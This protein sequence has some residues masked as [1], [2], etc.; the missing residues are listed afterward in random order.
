MFLPFYLLA[1]V[2]TLHVAAP[3]YITSTFL[4]GKIGEGMVG[5]IYAGASIITLACFFF[6]GSLLKKRGDY[7]LT[8]TLMALDFVATVGLAALK[9]PWAIVA[10]FAI[11]FVTISLISFDFDLLLESFSKNNRTGTVRG[12]YLT[13]ANIAWLVSPF[14]AGLAL[15]NGDYWRIYLIALAFLL[16]AFII[17]R[18][19]FK[20]FKDPEYTALPF[21]ST[22][23]TIWR[24]RS[25]RLIFGAAFILQ[26]FYALMV[27][28]TPI[29]LHEHIGF[30]W[31][32]IGIMFS[33]MLLPFVF[34]EGPLGRI[35]DRWLG[36]K[37][38]LAAGFVIAAVATALIGFISVP[39]FALWTGVLFATRVGASMIE[40]MSETYFF[41]KI[42]VGDAAVVAFYRAVRP[43]AY[44]V[45]PAFASLFLL[46]FPLGNLFFALAAIVLAGLAFTIPLKDTR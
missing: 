16:A 12:N 36:E 25:V 26:F 2:F 9:T 33:I 27:I 29:Y 1:F 17:F 5:F 3:A 19:F 41:K 24:K 46:S 28:Y 30:A 37:E 14:I 42:G 45:A 18:K 20:G 22:L 35:A 34:L 31:Q 21:F 38:F 8:L 40:I 11:N 43:L 15:K 39:S 44:V 4:S 7:D 32:E 10:A 13:V 6:I 23:R